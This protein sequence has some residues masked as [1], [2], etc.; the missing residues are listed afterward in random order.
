M[1]WLLQNLINYLKVTEY[2]TI[3]IYL[4]YAPR[5]VSFRNNPELA[6]VLLILVF[7]SGFFDLNV[8]LNQILF[9]ILYCVKTFD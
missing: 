7:C 5:F 6:F 3:T 4:S 8:V 9:S 1:C 2:D